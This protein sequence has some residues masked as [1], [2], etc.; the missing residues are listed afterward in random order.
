MRNALAAAM[1]ALATVAAAQSRAIR[2]VPAGVELMSQAS[3]PP[4]V[5]DRITVWHYHEIGQTVHPLQL[6]VTE[7]SM[8]LRG[9]SEF[10]DDNGN[11][12]YCTFP[13]EIP[14]EQITK[15]E[16]RRGSAS[17]LGIARLTKLH[18]EYADEKG[19]HHTYDFLSQD[20]REINNEWHEGPAG[21]SDLLRFAQVAQNAASER[22]EE[23]KHPLPVAGGSNGRLSNTFLNEQFGAQ[24]IGDTRLYPATIHAP[25]SAD[26]DTLLI[27]SKESFGDDSIPLGDILEIAIKQRP[28]IFVPK[29]PGTIII[30]I[31]YGPKI[32]ILTL[33][34]RSAGA[35]AI[36]YRILSDEAVCIDNVPCKEGADNGQHVVDL[37]RNI[38]AAIAARTNA[39]SPGTTK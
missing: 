18:I 32:N 21:G 9:D 24:L 4:E 25:T 12:R 39:V 29:A 35:K 23:L 37:A 10:R 6:S 26:P 3:S 17:F 33:K 27:A 8:F 1:I 7:Y 34:V 38:K 13:A 31:P 28:F 30:G 14:L 15:V 11:I 22:V 20:A 2:D 19:K 5:L 36:T 16:A